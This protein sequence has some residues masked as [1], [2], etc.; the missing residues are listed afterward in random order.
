MGI[1]TPCPNNGSDLYM[2]APVFSPPLT[3]SVRKWLLND[4]TCTRNGKL[5]L[6]D[7]VVDECLPFFEGECQ[8]RN[9]VESIRYRSSDLNYRRQ[10]IMGVRT[11]YQNDG[12]Y[13]Y[14]LTPA[15]SPPSANTVHKWLLSD[16]S[17]TLLELENEFFTAFQLV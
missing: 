5:G 7:G 14:M 10:V 1:S 3:D 9:E 12:S 15:F 16:G 4:G 2:L 11:H 6:Q 8:E 13:L 17:G